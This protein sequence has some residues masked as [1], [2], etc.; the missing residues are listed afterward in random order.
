MWA[1][2]RNVRLPAVPATCERK[3]G[4]ERRKVFL[5]EELCP[6]EPAPLRKSFL[7]GRQESQA[8]QDKTARR[9]R[10]EPGRNQN[11]PK[12]R[13]NSTIPLKTSISHYRISLTEARCCKCGQ[14]HKL[15]YLEGRGPVHLSYRCERSGESVSLPFEA[16][17]PIPTRQTSNRAKQENRLAREA[18]QPT[19]F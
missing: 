6:P 11:D 2:L 15:E 17:L 7:R 8:Q 5:R 16:G 13:V 14:V 9:A 1:Q 12:K 4:G 19:L 10:A 3:R 18:A